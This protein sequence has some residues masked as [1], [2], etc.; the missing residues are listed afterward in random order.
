MNLSITRAHVQRT[1]MLSD[2]PSVYHKVP[3]DS[4][5]TRSTGAWGKGGKASSNHHRGWHTDRDQ[6]P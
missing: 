6:A 2:Q 5:P 4:V 3:G 1:N